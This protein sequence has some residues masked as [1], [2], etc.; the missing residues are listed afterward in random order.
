MAALVLSAE[1]VARLLTPASALECTQRALLSISARSVLNPVRWGMVLPMQRDGVH[2]LGH[3]PAY[4]P[5]AVVRGRAGAGGGSE[6]SPGQQEQEEEWFH[7]MTQPDGS[8]FL[9]VIQ[10][11]KTGWRLNPTLLF[12]RPSALSLA[13]TLAAAG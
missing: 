7:P 9:R 10:S 13:L 12:P 6:E 4:L 2:V 3:M 5:E 8:A 11:P 1:T